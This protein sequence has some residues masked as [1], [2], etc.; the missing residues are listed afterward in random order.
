M[1]AAVES[2]AAGFLVDGHHSRSKM[3]APWSWWQRRKAGSSVECEEDIIIGLREK[4]SEMRH[5]QTRCCFSLTAAVRRHRL[6]HR[7]RMT[8]CSVKNLIKVS[9]KMTTSLRSVVD[10]D[11]RVRCLPHRTTHGMPPKSSKLSAYENTSYYASGPMS[12]NLRHVHYAL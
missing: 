2:V 4:L 9:M 7:V 1:T 12:T 10:P 6:R 8:S 11:L 3:S 5:S